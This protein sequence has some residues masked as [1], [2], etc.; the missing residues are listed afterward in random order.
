MRAS[1]NLS[2]RWFSSRYSFCLLSLRASV[3]WRAP[4]ALALAAI[5]TSHCDFTVSPEGSQKASVE[6]TSSRLS[7][8]AWMSSMMSNSALLT[9]RAA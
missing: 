6:A 7:W 1:A 2:E 3:P 8:T 9:T 5:V 4:S